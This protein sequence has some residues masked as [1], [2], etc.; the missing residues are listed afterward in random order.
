MGRIKLLL[1]LGLELPAISIRLCVQNCICQRAECQQVQL[2]GAQRCRTRLRQ[3]AVGARRSQNAV[4]NA[5]AQLLKQRLLGQRSGG[6]WLGCGQWHWIELARGEN[7]RS[8]GK[9]C[10]HWRSQ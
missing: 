1:L 6:Q 9:A 10:R 5:R 4:G 7:Q 3:K 8:T 2:S